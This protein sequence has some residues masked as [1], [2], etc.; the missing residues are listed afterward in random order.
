MFT[1]CVDVHIYLDPP[2]SPW[3]R[4]PILDKFDIKVLKVLVLLKVQ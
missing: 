4:A 1:L 2:N 3:N